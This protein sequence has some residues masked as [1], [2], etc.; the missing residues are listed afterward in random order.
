MLAAIEDRVFQD[1]L[2]NNNNT[3]K[4]PETCHYI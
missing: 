3:S 4:S 1:V 2:Q